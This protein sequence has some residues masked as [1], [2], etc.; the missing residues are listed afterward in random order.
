MKLQTCKPES[1]AYLLIQPRFCSFNSSAQNEI[2]YNHF[3]FLF[4]R[5][6]KDRINKL[7]I[8]SQSKAN[9]YWCWLYWVLLAEIYS[10]NICFEFYRQK[11]RYKQKKKKCKTHPSFKLRFKKLYKRKCTVITAVMTEH[12]EILVFSHAASFKHLKSYKEPV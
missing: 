1:R 9:M 6:W 8:F 5:V 7:D 3:F 10:H 2:D 11:Q 4:Y 12:N